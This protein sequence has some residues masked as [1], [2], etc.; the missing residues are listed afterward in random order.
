M[1][2]FDLTKLL[3]GIVL[4]LSVVCVSSFAY[5]QTVLP[6]SSDFGLV[7][8]VKNGT[9]ADG[10][11]P[12]DQSLAAND[13]EDGAV[14]SIDEIDEIVASR[15]SEEEMTGQN[16]AQ[17]GAQPA[18]L[19][20]DSMLSAFFLDKNAEFSKEFEL[21][22]CGSITFLEPEDPAVQRVACDEAIY[23][24]RV[25]GSVVNVTRDEEIVLALDLNSSSFWLNGRH[26]E[27]N[28]S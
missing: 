18:A 4:S 21:G 27:A 7:F 25:N 6:E 12:D 24:Y 3:T 28:G 26:F 23:T 5:S 16:E 22:H 8:S 19:Y 20:K 2:N 17:S 10:V 1:L 9:L 15:V 11:I 13:L 14:Y